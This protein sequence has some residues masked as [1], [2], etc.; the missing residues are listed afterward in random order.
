MHTTLCSESLRISSMTRE[1]ISESES[2][3]DTPPPQ[4]PEEQGIVGSSPFKLL[5][6]CLG[7]ILAPTGEVHAGDQRIRHAPE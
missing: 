6:S 5:D 2:H 1:A 3:L 7:K 4:S